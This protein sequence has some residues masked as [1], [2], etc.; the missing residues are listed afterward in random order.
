MLKNVFDLPTDGNTKPIQLAPA[1]AALA[2]TVDATIS[3]STEITLN[4]A[5]TLIRVYAKDK[6]ICMKWG[7]DDVTAA[8]FD[9][10]IPANQICDFVV[11][12][13]TTAANF[14]EYAATATLICLEF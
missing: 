4:A 7:T 9:Q 11:P 10:I 6:D 2:C 1:K 3:G 8:A 5:T 12:Q 13:N 14:I